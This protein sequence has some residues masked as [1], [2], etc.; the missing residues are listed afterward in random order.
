MK[1]TETTTNV[2]KLICLVA[3]VQKFSRPNDKLTSLVDRYSDYMSEELSEDE[4]M[5][6][7]AATM[8]A[9]PKYKLMQNNM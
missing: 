3:G 9:V 1:T 5:L 7:T 6:A 8:P 2:E 4:L